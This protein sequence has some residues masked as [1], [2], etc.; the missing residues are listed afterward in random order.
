M[1]LDAAGAIQWQRLPGGSEDGGRHLCPADRGRRLYPPRYSYSSAS[2]DVTGTSRGGN[3]FWVVKSNGAG[4]L[5]WQRLL[6]GPE[7]G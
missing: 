4:T 6:G 3:G 1:K 7:N 5:S 2:G